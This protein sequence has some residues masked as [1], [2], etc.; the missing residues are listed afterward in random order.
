MEEATKI[1]GKSAEYGSKVYNSA[2][3]SVENF[4]NS[5][6]LS[7]MGNSFWNYMW[8]VTQED[9]SKLGKES[10]FVKEQ[11]EDNKQT[12]KPLFGFTWGK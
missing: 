4:K 7:E 5:G 12:E 8:T 11:T 10:S 3:E 1:A 2:K 9:Q 6:Q